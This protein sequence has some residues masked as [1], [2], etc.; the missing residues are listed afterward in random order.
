[1]NKPQNTVPILPITQLINGNEQSINYFINSLKTRGYV[2]V[3]LPENLIKK[4]DTN[5][6]TLL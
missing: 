6:N 4:I 2:Y 5:I 3:K 1:M